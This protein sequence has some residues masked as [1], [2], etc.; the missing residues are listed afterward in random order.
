[1]TASA[2]AESIE[3]QLAELSSLADLLSPLE[4]PIGVVKE[5]RQTTDDVKDELQVS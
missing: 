4:G 5:L 3:P 2:V 1:M